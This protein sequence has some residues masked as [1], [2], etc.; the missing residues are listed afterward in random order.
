[1]P[2]TGVASGASETVTVLAKSQNND[3]VSD[4]VKVTTSTPFYACNVQRTNFPETVNTEETYNY[5]VKFSN[6]GNIIDTYD[7]SLAGGIW[8]YAIRN[9]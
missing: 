8:T 1:M 7:L 9:A 3:T 5:N 2:Q 4:Q 6:T